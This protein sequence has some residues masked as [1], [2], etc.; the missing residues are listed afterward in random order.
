M[1]ARGWLSTWSGLSSQAELA[2]TLVIGAMADMD[3][4]LS[5][6]AAAYEACGAKDKMNVPLEGGDPR[7]RVAEE[8]VLP[9]VRER[10]G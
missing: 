6:T 3:I 5:E 4:Y 8:V 1:S 10:W 7:R 2:L 9:W